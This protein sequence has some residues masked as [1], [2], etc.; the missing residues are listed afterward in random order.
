MKRY[1]KSGVEI[2]IL[3]SPIDIIIHT[4]VPTKYV[5]IDEE[6]GQQYRGNEE[7]YWSKI[8]NTYITHMENIKE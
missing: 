8:D 2:E 6:T 1:L 3:P 7:G 4:K 5:L